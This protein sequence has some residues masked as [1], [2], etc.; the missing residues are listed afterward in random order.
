MPVAVAGKVFDRP[1]LG[2]GDP[3]DVGHLDSL[4]GLVW[5]ALVMWL[6]LMLLVALAG[7]AT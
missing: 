6:L 1:P 7:A 2:Q 4:V 3:A 5:R